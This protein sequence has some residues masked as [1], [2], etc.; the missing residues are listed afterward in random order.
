LYGKKIGVQLQARMGLKNG[1][2]KM[3]RKTKRIN[4]KADKILLCN[5][6]CERRITLLIF[7]RFWRNKIM[8]LEAMPVK[9]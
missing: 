1:K 8:V 6:L 2:F 9:R 3:D 4:E 5:G 7:L